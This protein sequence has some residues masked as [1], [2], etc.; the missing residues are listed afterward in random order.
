MQCKQAAQAGSPSAA[1]AHSG[2]ESPPACLIS[3]CQH[4]RHIAQ[5]LN[6]HS[7]NVTPSSTGS[8]LALDAHDGSLGSSAYA[9]QH[10]MPP[11]SSNSANRFQNWSRKRSH[12][13]R[14]T[15][16]QSEAVRGTVV[17]AVPGGLGRVSA[18][19]CQQWTGKEPGHD[20]AGGGSS[21]PHPFQLHSPPLEHLIKR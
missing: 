15:A 21:T 19:S 3:T 8:P 12:S 6:V 10:R 18:C 1:Y 16:E 11:P 7:S 5:Q 2:G 17:S 14:I 4:R 20:G 13:G 9:T